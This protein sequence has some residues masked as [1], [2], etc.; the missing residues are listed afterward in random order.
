MKWGWEFDDPTF[1]Q[2]NTNYFYPRMLRLNIS[3]SFGQMQGGITKTKR[4]IKNE[5]VKSGESSTGGG[6]GN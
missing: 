4:G 3:Y 1:T 2:K 6:T 5:D